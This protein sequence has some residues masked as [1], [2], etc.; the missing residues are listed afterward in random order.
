MTRC[1]EWRESCR[2]LQTPPHRTLASC[3]HDTT[4][5]SP[6][7]RRL[8]HPRRTNLRLRLGCSDPDFLDF[9]S[10]MLAIDPDKRPTA[11]QALKH[12]WLTKYYDFEPYVLPQM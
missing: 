9:V 5:P 7:Y 11:A 4:P 12:P 1:S 2:Q 3:T 8:M 6:R 10:A